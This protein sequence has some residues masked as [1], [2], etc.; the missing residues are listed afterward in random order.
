[1]RITSTI[2]LILI[3]SLVSFQEAT[4]YAFF[5][6][7]Q[8][9]IA[10]NLCVEKD[11]N[12]SKCKGHCQLMKMV[13]ASKEVPSPE[14]PLPSFEP[15]KIELFI[16]TSKIEITPLESMQRHCFDLSLFYDSNFNNSIFRPPIA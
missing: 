15:T 2:F 1:M 6:M 9:Y 8:D 3:I 16:L 10:K 12:E 5:K 7:N 13:K 4:F 11:V 14:M